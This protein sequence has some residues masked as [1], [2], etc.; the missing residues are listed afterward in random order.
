MKN[1]KY[2]L[3]VWLLAACSGG[4]TF[5]ERSE[6]LAEALCTYQ[7][8]CQSLSNYQSCYQDVVNDMGDAQEKLA[9][10]GEAACMKCMQAKIEE[11]E[12]ASDSSCQETPSQQRVIEACG[13]S[14]DEACAGYP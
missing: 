1:V 7:Q 12:K 4:E 2:A 8:K 13:S 11:L 5:Q 9:E 10:E 3:A 6:H 14:G